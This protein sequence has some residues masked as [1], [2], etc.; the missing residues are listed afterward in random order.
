MIVEMRR[1]RL[2]FAAVPDVEERYA[3]AL[4]AR[5][6]LSPLGGFWHTEVGTLNQVI[7]IWPYESLAERERVMNQAARL[8]GWPPDIQQFVLE[9]DLLILESLPFSPPIK[10]RKLGNIYEIRTYSYGP[11]FMPELIKRWGDKIEERQKLSPLVGAWQTIIGPLNKLVHI[12]AYNDAAE[13]QR[14]R[15]KAVELGVWPPSANTVGIL[16]KQ[17]NILAIPAAF[18]PLH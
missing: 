3:R 9:D 18:S 6:K 1:Q 7:Q 10:P 2:K 13:R 8:A 17:E 4:P 14:I 12:W 16:L 11:G 15:A 5:I